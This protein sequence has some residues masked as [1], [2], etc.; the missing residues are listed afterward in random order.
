MKKFFILF[1]FLIALIFIGAQCQKINTSPEN[2]PLDPVRIY[3]V[4]LK[5]NG[6][7][8]AKTDIYLQDE[9]GQEIYFLTLENVERGRARSTAYHNG[10]VYFIIRKDQSQGDQFDPERTD[11]LWQYDLNKTGKKL[12]AKFGLGF[13][14]NPEGTYILASAGSYDPMVILDTEGNILHTYQL[15]K[16]VDHENLSGTYI[17]LDGW[18]TTIRM[19]EATIQDAINI[20]PITVRSTYWKVYFSPRTGSFAKQELPFP[21]S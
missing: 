6:T 1:P 18:N 16:L 19:F 17:N 21:S 8:S 12:Y 5:E 15:Q 14:M 3:E 7:N 11:E 2:V 20:D 13:V 4:V 10:N 9:Q